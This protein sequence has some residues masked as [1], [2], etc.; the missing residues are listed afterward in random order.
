MATPCHTPMLGT[1]VAPSAIYE[2]TRITG[3]VG[4]IKMVSVSPTVRQTIIINNITN[5]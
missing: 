2:G 3:I 1:L 5:Y 4:M